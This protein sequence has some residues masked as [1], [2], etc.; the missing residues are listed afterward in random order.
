MNRHEEW[1]RKYWPFLVGAAII[2]VGNVYF[3]GVMEAD[4]IPVGPATLVAIVVVLFLELGRSAYRRLS[5]DEE[6]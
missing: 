4:W 5:A 1:A 6:E 2:V 3:Y